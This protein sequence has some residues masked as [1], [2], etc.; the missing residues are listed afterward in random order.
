MVAR[1]WSGC[2]WPRIGDDRASASS[3]PSSI[4]ASTSALRAFRNRISRP[5]G[6]SF[7]AFT[8]ARHDPARQLLYVTD[9][10]TPRATQL[11]P[12]RSTGQLRDAPKPQVGLQVGRAVGRA[13]LEPATG[14]L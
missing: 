6:G 4:C 2:F 1:R 5:V 14:R 3:L 10:L 11:Q 8:L 7:P 13:G 12:R 9:G